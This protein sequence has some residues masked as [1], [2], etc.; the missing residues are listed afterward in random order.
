MES[1]KEPPS[2]N[3]EKTNQPE[4]TPLEAARHGLHFYS[5]L[6]T[7]DGHWAGDYGGPHFL[8]PGLIVVWYVMGQPSNIIDTPQKQSMIHYLTTHQQTDGGWGTHI[9][10]PSTMFGS[11]LCYVALRLLGVDQEHHVCVK[12]RTFIRENGGALYTSSWAK[13]YLCLLGCME[14]EGHNSVPPEMWL[15]P[16]WCP[17]HPGRMWCHARMVYLPMGYLYGARFVYPSARNDKLIAA[18]RTELYTESSGPYDNIDWMH[19]R[20]LVA[21]MDNY[22]PVPFVMKYA[23]NALAR[24][25]T[26][27]VFSPIRNF[28]RRRGMAFCRQYMVAEDLQT[29]YINIGPVNKVL[30]LLSAYHAA[31]CSI[32]D[33]AV[34]SHMMRI[35]DYLWLAEDGMKMQGYNGSQCWDTSF[36]IQ[37]V[38]ECHLSDVFP[39][40]ST[41]VWDYLERT[42]ILST[43]AS[44]SSPAFAYESP[45]NRET[46]Y[47]H[48]SQ[49]GWPF[50]TS[51]H[52]WPISDCTG[53]GLKGVLALAKNC[54]AVKDGIQ[55]GT[56][57]AIGPNRLEDAV[58]VL[59]TMQNEDGGW[60]TYENNR[61]FGFYEQ[62]NPSEVFGDIMID[63]SYVECSMASMTALAEFK[64]AFPNH[65]RKQEICESLQRGRSFLKRIQ[66]PDGSW[67]GSWAC[68]FT[69][70]S[71]FGIEGL[72]A[73]GEPISTSKAIQKACRFLLKHQH[74]N[75]GWGEDFTSCYDKE[76]AK[77]G[78]KAYGDGEGEG[79][80][81]VNTAWALLAL[82]A[83]KCDDVE[84]VR[85]G[86]HYLMRRQLPCGDWPQ[87]GISGVFNRA[88][89]I[90]YTSYRN[91]FP[92]WALGRCANVYGNSVLK[93]ED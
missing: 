89:G 4:T 26:W 36:A 16:N 86:V 93:V 83:A 10:S 14:W 28:V 71:W 67:Y 38:T 25:E 75:G 31:N 72:V 84:A 45:T 27:S 82:A 54:Q 59:L 47:R 32:D 91:V 9:E 43:Q 62:L 61:G 40:V 68:C 20:H 79:S 64:K 21:P 87:E 13:F 55:A 22:S 24:Y 29:N 35:P 51:A 58:N 37:A 11:V 44:Q 18:L 1:G 3:S 66:R 19:T 34:Q 60:A 48:V 90:T 42:Q 23:Q 69:Y 92:I 12:G 57:R 49:G 5:M 81:V 70:G 80:G 8:L 74:S 52:G 39:E 15:L 77:D 6:Q 78:M 46:F 56:L 41:K 7:S 33:K 17:F 2:T 73:A 63:Y 88:C 53:E 50:S 85:R 76:Y 30:N 65:A